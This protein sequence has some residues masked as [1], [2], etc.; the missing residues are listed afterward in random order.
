MRKETYLHDKEITGGCTASTAPTCSAPQFRF[1][2][3]YISLFSHVRMSLFI[4]PCLF[5]HIRRICTALA[6]TRRPPKFTHLF[7][8][9]GLFYRSLFPYVFFLFHIYRI[10]TCLDLETPQVYTSF[11]I[12]RSLL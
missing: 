9:T 11:F 6:S 10:C 2:L 12:Y 8:C 5:S 4:Y 1:F 3:M 7:S